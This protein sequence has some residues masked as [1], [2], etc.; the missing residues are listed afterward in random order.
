ME[1]VPPFRAHDGDLIPRPP[2][3]TA[4]HIPVW[5]RFIDEHTG[6]IA[7]HISHWVVDPGPVGRLSDSAPIDNFG[8]DIGN[9]FARCF[10]CDTG[11]WSVGVTIYRRVGAVMYVRC[12]DDPEWDQ[13]DRDV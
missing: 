13:P 8:E 1:T 4:D 9:L 11:V 12:E 7:E 6:E 10:N 3:A 5:H 2:N